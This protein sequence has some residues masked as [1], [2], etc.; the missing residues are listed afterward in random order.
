MRT[1]KKNGTRTKN[2][3]LPRIETADPL[4]LPNLRPPNHQLRRPLHSL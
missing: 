1:T 4:S 3:V 2:G